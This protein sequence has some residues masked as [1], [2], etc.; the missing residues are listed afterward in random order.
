MKEEKG[1]IS[2][3]AHSLRTLLVGNRWTFQLFLD[4]D[5]GPLS[6]EQKE[7][8][9]KL[10]ENNEQAISLVSDLLTWS[11]A[12]DLKVK[13]EKEEIDL[14]ELIEKILK[15]FEPV[16]KKKE[17]KINFEKL[18]LPKIKTEPKKIEIILLNLLDNAL[19]YSPPKSQITV[20]IMAGEKI[21]IS[22]AD[23]GIGI[24]VK[25]QAK[26]FEKFFRA[27]NAKKKE[28]VGTGLGLYISKELVESLGGK[29]WFESK[30]N[31]GSTFYFT[32]AK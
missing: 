32:L 3:S 5:L 28:N 25:E 31:A 18:D 19:R 15:Q 2:S 20:K 22:V 12:E 27:E 7:Y 11:H 8:L 17:I 23:Q 6:T 16:A 26:I 4:G 24:P 29:I 14:N 9:K 21:T 10:F 30:E 13:K 1:I